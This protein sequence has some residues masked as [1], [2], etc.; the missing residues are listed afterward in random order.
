[1]AGGNV[2]INGYGNV[3]QDAKT[4][5]RVKDD[6]VQTS[7]GARVDLK[8]AKVLLGLWMQ[9]KVPIGYVIGSYTVEE[10]EK[11]RIKIGCH[12]LLREEI[13]RVA[14]QLEAA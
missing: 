4:Y 7:R 11:D 6:E 3:Q 10:V 9:G 5:L 12:T 14:P 2:S 1:M 8:D 13:E